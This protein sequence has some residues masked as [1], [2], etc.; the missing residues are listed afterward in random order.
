MR[1]FAALAALAV[2]L[3]V[4]AVAAGARTLTLSADP[5]NKL[6]FN[7]KFLKAEAGKVTIVMTNPSILPHNVAIK[8]K[9][10]DL[11]G[12]IV[13]KGGTSTVTATLKE[14]FYTFY[15]SVPGHEAGGMKGTLK[16]T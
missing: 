11:K 16:I 15:C 6:A 4:A 10:A 8:G 7:K 12:K 5:T 14:G 1:R 13:P 9:G 3:G 2:F